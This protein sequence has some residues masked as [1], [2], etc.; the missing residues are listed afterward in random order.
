[1]WS[2]RENLEEGEGLSGLAS[3]GPSEGF[4]CRMRNRWLFH[5]QIR[6]HLSF[7]KRAVTGQGA[8]CSKC[9]SALTLPFV[10]LLL[11]Q[12]PLEADPEWESRKAILKRWETG[13]DQRKYFPI[14]K[15]L[16]I[17]EI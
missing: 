5:V 16:V 17:L 6:V 15:T 2:G 9:N 4:S 1:M 7:F 14:H 12:V 13:Q 8:K 3:M 11:S 10:R